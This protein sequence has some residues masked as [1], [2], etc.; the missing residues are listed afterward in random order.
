MK[1]VERWYSTDADL[2][3]LGPLPTKVRGEIDAHWALSLAQNHALPDT[4]MT[5]NSAHF[6]GAPFACRVVCEVFERFSEGNF[7][8]IPI[9]KFWSLPDNETVPRQYFVVNVYNSAQVVDLERSPIETPGNSN[10]GPRAIL[11]TSDP[12]AVFVNEI[13]FIDH[14]L[15]RDTMTSEWFCDD[16]FR[17]AIEAVTPGTYEFREVNLV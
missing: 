17:E 4:F 11:Y 12:K 8:L 10:A 1:G 7:E 13:N 5:L 3:R 9:K 14:H 16:I 15:L 6:T 2:A